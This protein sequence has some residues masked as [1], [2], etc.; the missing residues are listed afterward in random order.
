MSD[1]KGDKFQKKLTDMGL[2]ATEAARRI[3]ISRDTIHR[4]FNK[5]ELDYK[6]RAKIRDGLGLT[7]AEIWGISGDQVDALVN[8]LKDNPPKD[9]MLKVYEKGEYF[10]WAVGEPNLYIVPFKSYAGFL[11]GYGDG[12]STYSNIE[13]IYYPLIKGEAYAFQVGGQSAYPE[14]PESTW[15]CGKP[16][17]GPEDLVKGRIYTW[18]TVDGIV[19]KVF[20]KM[21]DEYFYISSVNDDFN[22]VKP[23]HRKDVKV[24]Y[25]K[26]G[27]LDNIEN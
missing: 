8:I 10:N 25:R 11:R 27:K 2:S 26:V 7:D 13:K 15:F 5:E 4:W 17:A 21:D 18:Q 23:L 1:Y 12:I 14:F 19:T 24:I 16:I 6:I 9:I 22:P 20:D 3:G